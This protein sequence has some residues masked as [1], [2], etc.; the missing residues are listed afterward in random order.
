MVI[1]LAIICK[2]NY[3]LVLNIFPKLQIWEGDSLLEKYN[4]QFLPMM[5]PDGYK[6]T[7]DTVSLSYASG[8]HFLITWITNI[9]EW[10]SFGSFDCVNKN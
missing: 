9:V 6:Y 8:E 3:T 2:Y 4:F 7:W 10:K 5:N 1:K